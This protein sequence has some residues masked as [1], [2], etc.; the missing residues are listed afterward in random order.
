MYRRS[1][2]VAEMEAKWGADWLRLQRIWHGSS[3]TSAGEAERT[4]NSWV[5]LDLA[6]EAAGASGIAGATLPVRLN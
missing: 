2:T 1:P 4:I 5:A 6:A 3:R